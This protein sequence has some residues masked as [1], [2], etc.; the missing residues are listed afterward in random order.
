MRTRLAA[1]CL[2]LSAV[3]PCAAIDKTR[4]REL[5]AKARAL[6]KQQDWQGVRDVLT[7]LR[8]IC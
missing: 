1:I 8:A 2:L 6:A 3:L 4:Y 7:T 5:N